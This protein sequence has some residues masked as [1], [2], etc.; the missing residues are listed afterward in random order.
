MQADTV[1]LSRKER[2]KIE[3]KKDI[4]EAAKRVF[5]EKGFEK[6]TLDEIAVEAEYGKGTLYNYFKN[7]EDLFISLMR[8]EL[9]KMN[10]ILGKSLDK[11][12]DSREQLK[13]VVR[14]AIHY[15]TE[16]QIF[17]RLLMKEIGKLA[18]CDSN[19]VYHDI[20]MENHSSG[21]QKVADILNNGIKKSEVKNIDTELAG[22]IFVFMLRA[23]IVKVLRFEGEKSI[24]KDIDFL[25]SVFY[26]GVALKK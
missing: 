8:H 5:A 20:L 16:N 23:V 24:E 7:K 14:A 15:A 6:A 9:N 3:R 25:V 11:Y 21:V 4:L 2:E 26:D 10:D 13:E 12:D 22:H 19:N 17:F 1:K 18:S